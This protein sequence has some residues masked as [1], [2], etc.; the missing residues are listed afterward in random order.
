MAMFAA[1]A[2]RPSTRPST[3]GSQTRSQR[4]GDDATRPKSAGASYDLKDILITNRLGSAEVASNAKADSM[5]RLPAP[6][7]G[8]DHDISEMHPHMPTPEPNDMDEFDG[9][10]F[11][12]C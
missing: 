9:I 11:I 6:D 3:S 12:A 1:N 2:P 8:F 7:Y 10:F 5:Q 4:Y